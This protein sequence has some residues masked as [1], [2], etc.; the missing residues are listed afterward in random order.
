M[1]DSQL[2]FM[3]IMWVAVAL[4]AVLAI[5]A[6]FRSFRLEHSFDGVV[7]EMVTGAR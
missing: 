5:D 2:M 1:R 7:A 4:T 3:G 6:E